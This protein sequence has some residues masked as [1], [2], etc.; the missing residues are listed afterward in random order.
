MPGGGQ[1]SKYRQFRAL[2]EVISSTTIRSSLFD[3]AMGYTLQRK[4]SK[5]VYVATMIVSAALFTLVPSSCS[6]QDNLHRATKL[7]STCGQNH[8]PC[9]AS[10]RV[11]ARTR[12]KMGGGIER[13]NWLA[14]PLSSTI[15]YH[16]LGLSAKTPSVETTRPTSRS[17]TYTI[18]LSSGENSMK[19]SNA[20]IVLT[21]QSLSFNSH[22]EEHHPKINTQKT[23]T[24]IGD[25]LNWTS[26]S[27]AERNLERW[28]LQI[29]L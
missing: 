7:T 15:A 22:R 23:H 4:T 10:E 16:T 8:A 2:L 9:N 6:R 3:V 12:N 27:V 11:H 29:L 25:D 20:F 1:G 18:P 14:F 28:K 19:H 26:Q 5:H 24:R 17:L 13:C 21:L